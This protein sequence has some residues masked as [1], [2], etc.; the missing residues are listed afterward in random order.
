MKPFPSRSKS[1]LLDSP[2]LKWWLIYLGALLLAFAG[3]S[4]QIDAQYFKIVLYGVKVLFAWPLI[5]IAVLS[6][7]LAF[8]HPFPTLRQRLFRLNTSKPP[9]Q[10]LS[11]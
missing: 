11:A 4:G 2:F 1:P 7:L 10:V 9:I 3:D 6:A 8:I 5:G